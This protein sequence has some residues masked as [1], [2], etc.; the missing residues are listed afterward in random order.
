MSAYNGSGTFV[1]SGVGLPYVTGT[2]ISSTV[3]NQLN[4]DL[5]TGLST[6]IAKDGQT[7]PTANIPFGGFKATGIAVATTTGDALSYGRAATVSSLADTGLL[8]ISGASAG[9]IQFPA[10]QNASA[11]ANTLDDYE[12]GTFNPTLD[13]DS[14]GFG[15]VTYNASRFGIYTKIGRLVTF[16][17]RLATDSVTIGSASGNVIVG[18]LPFTASSAGVQA[19]TISYSQAW[20]TS[21]PTSSLVLPSTTSLGTY[22]RSTSASASTNTLVAN[23]ATG[24][25]AN[26]VAISGS[27]IV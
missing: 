19:V 12:E 7:T 1:I 27:Y 15:A 14:V 26:D 13:T 23:V 10:T 11:N 3:A 25:A 17:L 8:D 9:Q 16:S 4:A 2:T 22:F 24:A 5:A 6:C 18:G 20:T 21:N